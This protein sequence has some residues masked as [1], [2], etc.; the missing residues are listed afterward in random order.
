MCWHLEELPWARFSALVWTRECKHRL[1]FVFIP[2]WSLH[3]RPVVRRICRGAHR[4]FEHEWVCST[5]K[6]RWDTAAA[7]LPLPP[8]PP[9]LVRRVRCGCTAASAAPPSPAR[10]SCCRPSSTHSSFLC[11]SFCLETCSCSVRFP[12]SGVTFQSD[13]TGAHVVCMGSSYTGTPEER[14][15]SAF[16]LFNLRHPLNFI[17]STSL[18]GA[19]SCKVPGTVFTY[20]WMKVVNIRK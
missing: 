5:L 17:S 6:P 15:C 13:R 12:R 11:G 8:P 9:P 14:V 2:Q 3:F 20:L 7:P 4:Q 10:A 16:T 18:R 19:F 1:V